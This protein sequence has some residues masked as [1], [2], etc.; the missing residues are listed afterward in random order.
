MLL[1]RKRVNFEDYSEQD[2]NSETK[3]RTRKLEI[4]ILPTQYLKIEQ[5][6]NHVF[7]HLLSHILINNFWL[8]SRDI[9]SIW[10]LM[11][12]IFQSIL[13]TFILTHLKNINM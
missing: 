4:A 8:F 11:R 10:H 5:N 1:E 12:L 2:L 13:T 6:F 9:F 3:N 7:L